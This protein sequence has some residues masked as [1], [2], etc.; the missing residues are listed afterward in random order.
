M[1]FFQNG[2]DT[3]V[4]MYWLYNFMVVTYVSFLAFMPLLCHPLHLLPTRPQGRLKHNQWPHWPL[5]LL[6]NGGDKPL[7][8]A[9]V[10]V[11]RTHGICDRKNARPSLA[12]RR[13]DWICSA[14]LRCSFE[15]VP[16]NHVASNRAQ[17]CTKCKFWRHENHK[18]TRKKKTL[19]AQYVYMN[20]YTSQTYIRQIDNITQIM[21]NPIM[22]M[23][24]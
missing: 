5:D 19:C 17:F 12:Q 15:R 10:L 7:G 1:C 9:Q 6:P 22:I 20:I 11:R 3:L 8:V 2:S 24:I 18:P 14:L 13:C 23:Y 4:K 16:G 21:Y